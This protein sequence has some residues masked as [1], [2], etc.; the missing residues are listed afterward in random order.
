MGQLVAKEMGDEVT[1]DELC[2]DTAEA[3]YK[4]RCIAQELSD[5]VYY[6]EPMKFSGFKVKNYF[7]PLI[8]IGLI[9]DVITGR[10]RGK[11]EMYSNVFNV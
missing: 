4:N 3:C 8:R 2:T 9:Y 6:T 1:G 10:G 7:A 11:P 5:M